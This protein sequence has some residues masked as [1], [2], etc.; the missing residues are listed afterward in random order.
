[1]AICECVTLLVSLL[2]SIGATITS[3]KVSHWQ[4]GDAY[5]CVNGVNCIL[6]GCY[7]LLCAHIQ[8]KW[9][10]PLQWESYDHMYPPPFSLLPTP[11]HTYS[12]TCCWATEHAM[13]L[14]ATRGLCSCGKGDWQPVGHSNE[15][16]RFNTM[17]TDLA[18]FP[19]QFEKSE[20][21]NEAD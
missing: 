15:H 18:S 21:G 7:Q 14:P 3:R 13:A 19:G 10:N 2:Q 12:H 4:G 11:P 9:H 1:M 5:L 20:N 6:T 16:H 8:L 17:L